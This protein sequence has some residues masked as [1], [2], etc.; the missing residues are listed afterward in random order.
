MIKDY[1]K[2]RML[3]ENKRN[4]FFIEVNWNKEVSDC[5][6]LKITFPDRKQSIIK[7]EHLLA[8][9]FAIGSESEQRRMVPQKLTQV[10]WYETVVS[11]KATKDINKGE[12]IT[13]PIKIT[14]PSTEEEVIKK[15]GR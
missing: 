10:K 2:F 14:L 12:Q 3:D 9:L 13:F 7:K 4:N 6:I 1:Q 11:I 15:Y 8:V 5:K